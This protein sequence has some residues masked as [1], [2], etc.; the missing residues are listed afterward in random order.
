MLDQLRNPARRAAHDRKAGRERLDER[1][2][3]GLDPR[4]E[5][6]QVG[7]AMAPRDLGLVEPAGEAHLRLEPRAAHAVAQRG[8]V[9]AGAD[10][11]ELVAAALEQR[12]RI[13]QIVEPVPLD[14][15]GHGQA[16]HDV[17]RNPPQ[18]HAWTEA[19]EVHTAVHHG[20]AEPRVGPPR[21]P[22]QAFAT[23]R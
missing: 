17:V 15:P 11:L 12:D 22:A 2:A 21:E 7:R 23:A 1:G 14:Q 20:V 3:E 5:G 10:D 18:R 6:E 4:R 16:A 13:D 9:R 8:L 19:G